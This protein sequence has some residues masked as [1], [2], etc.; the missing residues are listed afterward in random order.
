M[1]KFFV[2]VAAMFTLVSCSA[3]LEQE[4]EQIE[5]TRMVNKFKQIHILGSPTV[6]YTQGSKEYREKGFYRLQGR[7]SGDRDQGSHKLLGI[8]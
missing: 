7:P 4:E 5:E 8:Q 1:K 3:I 6:I 2:F